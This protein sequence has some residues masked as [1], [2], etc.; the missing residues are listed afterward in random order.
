MME[1]ED[2]IKAQQDQKLINEQRDN[3]ISKRRD[4]ERQIRLQKLEVTKSALQV[5]RAH[6]EQERINQRLLLTESYL[7]GNLNQEV[8]NDSGF[9][10]PQ[11]TPIDLINAQIN[12]NQNLNESPHRQDRNL[13]LLTPQQKLQ[14]QFQ[15]QLQYDSLP[16]SHISTPK[17]REA[18]LSDQI[19]EDNRYEQEIQLEKDKAQIEYELI[20][21]QEELNNQRNIAEKE[22]GR[23]NQEEIRRKEA[24]LQRGQ[25][26]GECKIVQRENLKQK[27]LLKQYLTEA[28]QLQFEEDDQNE[29][30]KNKEMKQKEELEHREY[31]SKL[32]NQ[33]SGLLTTIIQE[34][35]LEKRKIIPWLE[36]AKDMNKPI[37]EENEKQIQKFQEMIEQGCEII[38]STL[39][40]KMV[41]VKRKEIILQL[42]PQ[43]TLASPLYFEIAKLA[44]GTGCYVELPI[45]MCRP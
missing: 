5:Q 25:L 42:S 35:D 45:P 44:A 2:K 20:V 34:K 37:D 17:N 39:L 41:Y 19:N 26:Q 36:I 13:R 24:E 9:S 21:Q 10:Y 6:K 31:Q 11:I 18:Q 16:I 43:E 30:E 33:R 4:V 8:N 29:N 3:E 27:K 12:Q 40:G 1:E 22:Q 14:Q 38:K 32:H 15:L 23:A 28:E 7:I